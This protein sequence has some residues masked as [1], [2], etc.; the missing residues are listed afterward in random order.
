MEKHLKAR[1]VETGVSF[2]KTHDLTV[3]LDLAKPAEPMW[4]VFRRD[5]AILTECAVKFRYPG[6][7]VD[8]KTA[9]EALK[10]CRAFRKAARESMGLRNDR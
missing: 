1:L 4:E 7:S 3:L 2:P 5:L 10:I 9:I 6:E 8:K